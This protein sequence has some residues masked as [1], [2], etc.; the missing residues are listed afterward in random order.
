M[1]DVR[2]LVLNADYQPLNVTSFRKGYKLIYKGK[3]EVVKNDEK[4][5]ILTSSAIARPK[6]I[7]LLKYTYLPYRKINLSKQNV[8]KRDNFTCV[9]CGSGGNLTIDH[10]HPRSRGGANS[11]ENL[12]TCCRPCNFRKDNRTPEEARMKMKTRPFTP[13]F[14]HLI[15]LDGF[16]H[17]SI[18]IA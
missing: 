17:S 4:D 14:S 18:S 7:R 3:A 5:V 6:I 8:Y 2:I 13:T 11:W 15:E 16:D 10:V 9:Y 1:R 12:V